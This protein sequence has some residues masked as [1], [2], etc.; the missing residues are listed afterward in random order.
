[1]TDNPTAA[2]S[3]ISHLVHTLRAA[4][5]R[6]MR[7]NSAHSCLQGDVAPHK[8]QS[9]STE[10][11]THKGQLPCIS[12]VGLNEATMGEGATRDI[13][14]NYSTFSPN[15]YNNGQSHQSHLTRG[16]YALFANPYK[17]F[18]PV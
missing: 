6:S 4:Y 16:F 7:V 5:L 9:I 13:P 11:V 17:F 10:H 18:A 12:A 8:V 15:Y 2:D 1:M 3:R 14:C